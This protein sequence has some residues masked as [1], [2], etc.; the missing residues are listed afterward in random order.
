M[1]QLY[2]LVFILF[3]IAAVNGQQQAPTGVV[4]RK[5]SI[6]DKSAASKSCPVGYQM[7]GKQCGRVIHKDSQKT[8]AMGFSLLNASSDKCVRYVGKDPYCDEGFRRIGANCIRIS[9]TPAVENCPNGYFLNSNGDCLHTFKNSDTLVCPA[10]SVQRGDV[11]KTTGTEPPQLVCAPGSSLDGKRCLTEELYDC[12][13]E[14]R[15]P[16]KGKNSNIRLL[17]S[18]LEKNSSTNLQSYP[19]SGSKDNNIYIDDYVVKSTCKRVKTE[20]AKKICVH[21]VLNG[22]LCTI[23][24]EVL[25]VVQPGNIIEEIAK[26]IKSCPQGFTTGNS[27]LR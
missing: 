12:T 14:R 21:G 16:Q 26:P 25:P 18:V 22:K 7:M 15:L 5:P 6:I 9:T 19:S 27:S 10:G 8:C 4:G 17:G 13:P 3:L 2:S 23:E 20:P 24:N 11:C 1:R